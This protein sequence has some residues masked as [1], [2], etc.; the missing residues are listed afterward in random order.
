MLYSFCFKQSHCSIHLLS[1]L[2]Y[3]SCFLFY[4]FLSFLFNLVNIFYPI[5]TSLVEGFRESSMASKYTW[6]QTKL[7]KLL[8]V[9]NLF[10][11]TPDQ[12]RVHENY[13]DYFKLNSTFS[14]IYYVENNDLCA[15]WYKSKM[16]KLPIIQLKCTRPLIYFKHLNVK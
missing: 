7:L 15:L 5:F 13:T 4:F 8:A 6:F 1:I 10:F 2:E 16:T 3:F 12:P 14:S 11:W 9:S